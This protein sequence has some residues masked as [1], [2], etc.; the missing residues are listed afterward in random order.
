MDLFKHIDKNDCCGC[1]S[2]SQSCNKNA[3][4]M[5][6]EGF[7]FKFP[8]INGDI[9]VNCGKC[10]NSCPLNNVKSLGDIKYCYAS[11]TNNETIRKQSSSGG[12]FYELSSYVINKLNG[13]VFGAKFDDNFNVIMSYFENMNDIDAFMRSKYVQADTLN[14]FKECKSFLENNRTVLYTGTPCQINGL[15]SYLN[16]DYENLITVDIACHGVPSQKVWKTYLRKISKFRKIKS[17]NFRDKKNGWRSYHITITFENG[18]VLS[19]K[20][21]DNEYMK[22]FLQDKILRKSCYNCHFGNEYSKSDITIGDFWNIGEYHKN[23]DD[24]K[25]ISVVV[26]N[27]NKGVS[28]INDTSDIDCHVINDDS[29]K[30]KNGGFKNKLTLQKDRIETIKNY[31]KSNKPRVGIITLRLNNNIGGELQNFALQKIIKSFGY[32]PFTIEKNK[33]HLEFVDKYIQRRVIKESFTEIKENDFSCFVVGSDQIWRHKYIKCPSFNFLDFASDWK[34]KK[35]V[36]AASFG[37]DTWDYGTEETEK[38]KQL[39]KNFDA[40]SVRENN[41]LDLCQKHLGINPLWVLDPT[42]LLSKEDYIQIIRDY[43]KKPKG[44]GVF[45]YILDNDIDKENL[46]ANVKNKF[47]YNVISFD[48]KSV[49]DFLNSFY[50]CD[51]VVTDSFHGCVFSIIFN[52]PFVC[53]LNEKR[54]LGRFKSLMSMFNIKD[55]FFCDAKNVDIEKLKEKLNVD[56]Q[57]QHYKIISI[58]FL[59]TIML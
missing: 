15:K 57:Y 52:K 45:P 21:N 37:T 6:D 9:C 22:L 54:G 55:R 49:S 20:H 41:A 35:Y 29:Y 51:C 16:K 28:L 7:G 11:K 12:I 18:D 44:G 43:D 10:L 5:V 56:K 59:K 58:N 33:Q 17:V 39:I 3:I 19:E 25:G 46:I 24:N 30:K 14:T 1:G 31:I 36:Y 38:I 23:L 34:S 48:K 53:I 40:V 2:C 32:D 26:A 8:H 13:V 47:K 42:M 4:T 27:T 50:S